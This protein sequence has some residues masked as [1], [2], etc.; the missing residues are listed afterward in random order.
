MSE[1]PRLAL[2]LHIHH[3]IRRQ[4]TDVGKVKNKIEHYLHDELEGIDF[5]LQDDVSTGTETEDSGDIRIAVGHRA[6]AVFVELAP[7]RYNHSS[8]E[9]V[10]DR[11]VREIQHTRYADNVELDYWQVEATEP[12][13]RV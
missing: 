11:V 13:R 10:V 9:K 6:S 12:G 7:G 4:E 5:E 2:K 1:R 8:L 3:D